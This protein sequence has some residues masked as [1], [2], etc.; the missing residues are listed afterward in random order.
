ML[1]REAKWHA[2]GQ[3]IQSAGYWPVRPGNHQLGIGRGMI[4]PVSR[5][6]DYSQLLF[7]VLKRALMI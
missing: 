7:A 2:L 6:F 3:G 1:G 5:S 4:F